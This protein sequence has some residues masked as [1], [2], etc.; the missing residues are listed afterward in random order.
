LRLGIPRKR[1]V[2]QKTQEVSGPGKNDLVKVWAT[3]Q[4]RAGRIKLK[5]RE[6]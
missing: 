4:G 5:I 2:S 1:N 3:Q 6:F